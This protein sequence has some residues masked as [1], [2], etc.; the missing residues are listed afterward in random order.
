MQYAEE[1]RVSSQKWAKTIFPLSSFLSP[2]SSSL[3]YLLRVSNADGSS[4]PLQCRDMGHLDRRSPHTEQKRW[5]ERASA[6]SPEQPDGAAAA[7]REA[8]PSSALTVG[9]FPSLQQ[10]LLLLLRLFLLVL[11]HL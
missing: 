3:S 11:L 2:L 7:P 1:Q 5:T 10:H 9:S 4:L 6:L 8:D